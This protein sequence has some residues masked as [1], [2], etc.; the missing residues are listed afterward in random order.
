M[1]SEK[2]GQDLIDV[3]PRLVIVHRMPENFHMLLKIST[4][5]MYVLY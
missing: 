2:A 1:F 3:R 4:A 5:L